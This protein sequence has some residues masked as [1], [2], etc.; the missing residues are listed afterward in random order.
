MTQLK[1][2]HR[3]VVLHITARKLATWLHDILALSEKERAK[4]F[5]PACFKG[6]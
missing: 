2:G 6:G 1:R 4:G 5:G 3:S